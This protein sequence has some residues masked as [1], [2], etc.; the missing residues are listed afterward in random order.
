[1]GSRGS[2]PSGIPNPRVQD[3]VEQVD[4][5]VR[6]QE[7]QHQDGDEADDRRRVVAQDALVEV[8]ADAVDVEDPLGDD[9]AAHERA[10]VRADEGDHGD[11]RVAQ[12]VFGDHPVPGQALGD[13]RTDVVGP[14][15]L[16]DGGAG[17]PGDVGEGDGGEDQSGHDQ[18]AEGGV[19]GDRGS[20]PAPLDTEQQLQQQS[21]DEGR[22]RDDDEGEQQDT[23]VDGPAAAQPGDD[24][25]QDADDDLEEDRDDR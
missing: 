22:D 14:F 12:Q 9:G 5:Q 23:G 11:Q 21:G 25:Q 16:G 24:A 1:M 3:R 15:V 8:V 7:D 4:E 17:E 18:F 19:R 20:D 2:C 6:D 10:D 13:G